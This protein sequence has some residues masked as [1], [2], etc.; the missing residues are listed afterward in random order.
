MTTNEAQ[1]GAASSPR[2]DSIRFFPR[3]AAAEWRGRCQN[4][5]GHFLGGDVVGNIWPAVIHGPG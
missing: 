4:A 5:R 1:I 3:T 2:A